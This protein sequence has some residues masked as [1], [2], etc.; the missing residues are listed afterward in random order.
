RDAIEV[1]GHSSSEG[2]ESYNKLLSK[3]RSNTVVEYLKS[4]G[5]KNSLTSKGYGEAMPFADNATREGRIA[6]RRV[7]L[8]WDK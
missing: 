7:V 6:N 2:S 3:Q 1:Q 8:V 4:K 5:V